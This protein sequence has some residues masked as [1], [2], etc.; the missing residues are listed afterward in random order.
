[1]TEGI[2][3]N[4]CGRDDLKLSQ[5]YSCDNGY[6]ECPFCGCQFLTIPNKLKDYETRD[7]N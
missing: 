2:E 5:L 4:N 3:C 1:M 6:L 7:E